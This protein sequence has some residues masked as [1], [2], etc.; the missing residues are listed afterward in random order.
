MGLGTLYLICAVAGGTILLIK[1]VLMVIGLDSGDAP[2]LDINTDGG[3]DAGGEAGG[4]INFLSV[5]SIAGFFTMFGIVGLG[6]LQIN[7]SSWLSLLGALAAGAFTAW[8][9][10]MIFLNM[11]RL[12]S[13]GTLVIGNAVGQQGTVYLTIPEKGVGSINVTVQG[14]QRTLDAMSKDG[15]M[16]PTG[17]VVRVVGVA[18]G[19]ILVVTE[20]LAE[21]A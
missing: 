17:S 2:E 11:R 19:K 4:G 6:L 5:Q 21:S 14:A 13:D 9:T 7:A 16:V 1:L 10:A 20:D 12:Q 8:S 18:A 3:L 15:F